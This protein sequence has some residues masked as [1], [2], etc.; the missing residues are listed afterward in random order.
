M[1]STVIYC[2]PNAYVEPRSNVGK[3]LQ[4]SL[5]QSVYIGR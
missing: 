1:D 5:S 2:S 4:K 3:V